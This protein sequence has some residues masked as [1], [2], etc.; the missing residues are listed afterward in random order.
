MFII[1][2]III[3]VMAYTNKRNHLR[4]GTQSNI[5]EETLSQSFST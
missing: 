1:M 4:Q 3:A 2:F 5:D